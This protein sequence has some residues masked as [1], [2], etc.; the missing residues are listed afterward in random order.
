VDALGQTTVQFSYDLS[1]TSESYLRCTTSQC[2]ANPPTVCSYAHQVHLPWFRCAVNDP[3]GN[4]TECDF[5]SRGRCVAERDFTGR[6]TPGTL[7]TNALTQLSG[8]LRDSDPDF[9]ETRWTWNNDS[10]CTAEISPG[11]QQVRC[12]YQSDFDPA[13]P[14]RKRADCRVV[15]EIASS[16]VDLDG[17]GVTDTSER[18]SRFD[19]DPRFGSDPTPAYHAVMTKGT[20]AKV[21]I[22]DDSPAAVT[23][24]R[25]KLKA[26]TK[27]QGD[28]NLSNRRKGWDGSIK[29]NIA[30]KG[31]DGSIKG[32]V[33]FDVSEIDPR[34]NV[35][36]GSYDPNGN[37]TSASSGAG[38]GK[39]T[40]NPFSITRKIDCAY[41]THGQL[42]A[43]TNAPD[44]NGRRR[45]DSFTWSQGQ[46]TQCVVDAGAGGL[47][48]TSA[49]EYDAR[50]NLT[51]CV[52]P[53]TNDW[54]FTYNSLD[55][56]V[57]SS[58][59]TLSLCFC[60]IEYKY[61]YDAND[62]LVRCS[63]VVLDPAGNAQGTCADN[64]RYD[65]LQRLTECALAVDPSH[66]ITNRYGYDA[67][68]RC[69]QVL[70]P[71]AVS[72]VDQ[73][74]TVAYEYDER[75]LLFRTISAPGSGLD[76]TNELSYTPQG[77]FKELFEKIDAAIKKKSIA[78]DGF[79]RPAGSTDPMGNITT[80]NYDAND[81]LRVARSFGELTDVAGSAGNVRLAESRY[82][83]DG[84]DQCAV[85]HDLHFDPVTQSPVGDGEA[86]TRIVRCPSGACVSVTDD[87]GLVTTFG[88]DTA[89]RSSSAISAGA[90]AGIVVGVVV[91]RDACGNVTSVMETNTSTFG[92]PAQVLACSYAYDALSRL[93][94]CTDSAGNTSS[95]AYDSL[96]HVVRVTDALGND[97]TCA[98]DFMGDCLA[99]VSY[100]GS[101][102]VQPATVLR[103]RSAT[104]D[105]N[106]RCAS[107][108]DANGNTPSY[109]YDTLGNCT[110]VA[111]PDGTHQQLV[112]SPRS[113]LI[114]STDAN[115]TVSV[116]TY[117][118]NDRL[119]HRDIT[120]AAAG[121]GG[122]GG[123][124]GGGAVYVEAFSFDG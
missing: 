117:D 64:Y 62:N 66:V 50:G 52:D 80:F 112:W 3:V 63:T 33:R 30:R 98:Y 55:Q 69:V 25:E 102:S 58:S 121:G 86:T 1:A 35:T 47:A 65:S 5:D 72:G 105:S 73:H 104:Y 56:L 93:V 23:F 8:K 84:L 97:T 88:Y 48:L 38:A 6:A 57:Q 118:L 116:C 37:L 2:G 114:Q 94:S 36:T 22:V 85:V 74:Q 75:G 77:E 28:F 61:D 122:T 115:G 11:G 51:R 111:R 40:F 26:T 67:N 17:D 107:A 101:S 19:Y 31:W 41:D 60:K 68:S 45:V 39:I 109:A 42:T 7:V 108:T 24:G 82:E 20:G 10:L 120:M 9:F 91:A 29:G 13:T 100:A 71:D 96:G 119:I 15:R 12:V 81:N 4:V 27:T 70:G 89:G 16:P 46:M 110:V 99:S 123:A 113:N 53:G 21:S 124:G 79:S 44:A 18:V 32:N 14:A 34:G 43:I 90:I 87:L 106:L 59:A 83:Y 78:Y 49:F 95:C 76:R 54:L 92:G 103:S